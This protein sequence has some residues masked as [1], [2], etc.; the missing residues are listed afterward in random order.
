MTASRTGPMA[1]LLARQAS[2]TEWVLAGGDVKRFRSDL[3]GAL[4]ADCAHFLNC[5]KSLTDWWCRSVLWPCTLSPPVLPSHPLRQSVHRLSSYCT[6]GTCAISCPL[7]SHMVI[8]ALRISMRNR[9]VALSQALRFSVRTRTMI[10][11][12]LA[13]TLVIL[14]CTSK[15]RD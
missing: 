9:M 6:A 2:Q 5:L 15:K 8:V 10:H 14:R 4:P 13:C 11:Y 7:D 3:A 1:R 12:G